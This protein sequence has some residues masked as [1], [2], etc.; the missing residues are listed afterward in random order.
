MDAKVF[1]RKPEFFNQTRKQHHGPCGHLMHAARRFVLDVRV[2]A[3]K[4]PLRV[5]RHSFVSERARASC[6]RDTSQA[7]PPQQP[8]TARKPQAALCVAAPSPE[9]R[10]PTRCRTAEAAPASPA[11]YSP[12]SLPQQTFWSCSGCLAVSSFPPAA[13]AAVGTQPAGGGVALFQEPL[14]FHSASSSHS[15][16]CQEKGRQLRRG[17]SVQLAQAIFRSPTPIVLLWAAL[18]QYSPQHLPAA[19]PRLQTETAPTCLQPAPAP[20]TA[21]HCFFT[22]TRGSGT[23]LRDHGPP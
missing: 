12:A 3:Q 4:W 6:P 21:G 5:P 20:S 17:R 1:G 8:S 15:D 23:S 11:S 18:L 10:V 22:G 9:A 7:P 14:V 19:C 2:C 16:A 13:A